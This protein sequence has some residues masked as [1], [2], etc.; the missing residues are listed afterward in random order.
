MLKS[1]CR[2]KKL[3][4][5]EIREKTKKLGYS[6]FYVEENCNSVPSETNP[7]QLPKKLVENWMKGRGHRAN[8]INSSFKDTGVGIWIDRDRVYSSQIF[9][10]GPA[11][12]SRFHNLS[13]YLRAKLGFLVLWL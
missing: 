13:Y 4:S 3:S 8:I 1:T 5:N 9:G 7:D 12:T 6:S 10:K 2:P 11:R